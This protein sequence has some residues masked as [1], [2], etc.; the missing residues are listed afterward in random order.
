MKN[1][2][3]LVKFSHTIFALPFAMIGFT[4]GCYRLMLNGYFPCNDEYGDFISRALGI[5]ING[6]LSNYFYKNYNVNPVITFIVLKLF[7][8]L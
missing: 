7:L 5:K 1:Y 3:S 6:T 4:L 8:V 2:L